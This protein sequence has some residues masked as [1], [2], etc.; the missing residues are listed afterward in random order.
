MNQLLQLQVAPSIY[1]VE[2]PEADLRILCGCPEDAVKHLIQRGLIRT[3]EKDGKTFESGPNA[4]LLSDLPLQ[5]GFFTNLAEFP[6]LQ[7]LY[8][9]GMIL[10]GHPNNTGIKPLLIGTPE[11]ITAQMAYIY[12]GN[13]G[14]IGLGELREA[15]LDEKEALEIH[16]MKLGFAFG[17]FR[18]SEEL[19]DSLALKGN[20]WVEIRNQVQVRRLRQNVFEF[21]YRGET[22]TVDI[23][24][25]KGERN[26]STYSLGFHDVGRDYFSVVHSGQGDGW[27]IN[28]PSMSSVLIF[29]G[30]AYL[31]DAGPNVMYSL[32][33]LG[34]GVN[35][36][37]GVFH[38]HCHDDHFAGL[39]TLIRSDHRLKS[40]AAPLV[41]RSIFKKLSALLS[42]PEE[43]FS[44]YFDFHDLVCGAWNDIDGLEVLPSLSPHPVETTI[45]SFRAPWNDQYLTYA[46]LADIASL[47]VLGGMVAEDGSAPGISRDCFEKTRA[48]YLEQA[49]LKKIDIGGEMIHGCIEDFAEDKSER[50]IVA[51]KADPLTIREKALAS[52]APFGVTDVLIPDYADN[53]RR[54]AYEHLKAYFPDAP[55]HQ[56]RKLINNEIVTFKPGTILLRPGETPEHVHLLMTGYVEQLMPAAGHAAMLSS[57]GMIGE[58]EAL[59]GSPAKAAYRTVSYVKTLCLGAGTYRKFIKENGYLTEIERLYENLSV[60]ASTWLFGEVLT[61]PVQKRLARGM[62]LRRVSS[63]KPTPLDNL[64]PRAMYLVKSGCV[65]CL[66]G[67]NVI[68]EHGAGDFFGEEAAVFGCVSAYAYRTAEPTS[69]YEIPAEALRDIPI[70]LWKILETSKKRVC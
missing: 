65:Q 25:P 53:L 60:L 28:R 21:A 24:L 68:G 29:Q 46:H 4:I 3:A 12:R 52:S 30:K 32:T 57:G 40:F 17:R 13:Y 20:D 64:N 7:M 39:T 15:G 70:V 18:Q 47:D 58:C 26:L 9:Q 23:N 14:L 11:Q 43:A 69:L 1:W 51:H 62:V 5:Q 36:I 8:R 66:A 34:I 22:V 2:A 16:R 31:I 6:V 41:R 44:N 56:I 33:A 61:P 59:C 10:P 55:R 37:E 48:V 50:L 63:Q 27:D 49:K 35:E 54:T 38:T 19:L 42:M 45:M 67:D